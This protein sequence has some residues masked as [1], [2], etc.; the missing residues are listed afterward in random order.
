M[1]SSRDPRAGALPLPPSHLLQLIG[2]PDPASYESYGGRLF[3][4]LAQAWL[5][6]GGDLG[7]AGRVL[8][9]GCGCGRI[10]RHLLTH[11]RGEVHGCDVIP[12]MVEWCRRAFPAA[13][14]RLTPGLP[15]TDYPEASFQLVVG[16]SVMTHLDRHRQ[17]LWLQ[18]LRRLL[19]PGGLLLASTM[20]EHACRQHAAGR[21]ARRKLARLRRDGIL[22]RCVNSGL[23]RR[24]PD[25][26]ARDVYQT[27]AYTRA[28]WGEQLEVLDW[29]E[30]GA[31]G[32]Q[33]LVVL[34]KPG[35]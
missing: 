26:H 16:L 29:I 25:G 31:G 12:E 1:D 4:E 14:F 34:R 10:T 28:V 5:D 3:G 2:A 9:W 8:D 32:F 27:E 11:W 24:A 18:E 15:P 35:P 21:G 30:T 6:A 33:D 13:T 19:A 17:Q 20:G 22:D 7:A 23:A